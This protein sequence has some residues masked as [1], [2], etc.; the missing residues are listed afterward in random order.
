MILK[1]SDK[2]LFNPLSNKPFSEIVTNRKF[3]IAFSTPFHSHIVS[4][5]N[6]T[7]N[8]LLCVLT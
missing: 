7:V 8:L 4:R 5:S 1:G 2:C 3:E 6:D